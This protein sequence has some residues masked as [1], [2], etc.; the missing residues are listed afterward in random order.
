MKTYLYILVFLPLLGF[1]QVGIID[2]IWV[3]QLDTNFVEI[4]VKAITYGATHYE[5]AQT[6]VLNDTIHLDFCFAVAT[7]FPSVNDYYKRYPIPVADNHQ[8]TAVVTGYRYQ[9]DEYCFDDENWGFG[10]YSFSFSTPLTSEI[11]IEVPMLAAPEY[12]MSSQIQLYPNPVRDKLHIENKSRV[13]I[14]KLEVYDLNG[15]LYRRYIRPEA[16]VYMGDL[17]GGLYLVRLYTEQAVLTEK[18]LLA[19]A[20]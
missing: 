17:P 16:F 15:R 9:W 10:H 20:P 3:R 14:D 11:A 5:G 7:A 1:S 13:P 12:T 8:Y 6:M 2:S 19:P 4:E 18:I